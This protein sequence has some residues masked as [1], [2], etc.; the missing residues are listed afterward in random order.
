M[1]TV[2]ELYEFTVDGTIYRFCPKITNVVFSGSVF[3]PTIISR[4][5]IQ[6][7]DNFLKNT[8]I[9]LDVYK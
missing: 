1:A 3:V 9:E 6:I 7:T 8:R 5:P 2:T 4:G